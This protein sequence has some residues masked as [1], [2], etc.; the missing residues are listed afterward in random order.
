MYQTYKNHS[1]FDDC[2]EQIEYPRRV[3]PH[4]GSTDP[5]A[6]PRPGEPKFCT[7]CGSAPGSFQFVAKDAVGSKF[8]CGSVQYVGRSCDLPIMSPSRVQRTIASPMLLLGC[9]RRIIRTS[10]CYFNPNFNYT[11]DVHSQLSPTSTP[12]V[13]KT[14]AINAGFREPTKL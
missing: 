11:V 10:V 6:Y 3:K 12:P 8:S 7:M 5:I 1:K 9:V 2:A 14:N 4:A 13:P